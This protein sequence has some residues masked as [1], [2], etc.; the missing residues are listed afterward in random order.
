V[1]VALLQLNYTVGD[2]S[3][4]AERIR[5]SVEAAAAKGAK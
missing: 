2:L 3:G 4:N 1:K 5:A